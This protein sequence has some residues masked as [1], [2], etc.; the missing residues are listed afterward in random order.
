MNIIGGGGDIVTIF[1]F[2]NTQK[3]HA[4]LWNA[5]YSIWKTSWIQKVHP[6]AENLLQEI[7]SNLYKQGI[8]KCKNNDDD[9]Y[10]VY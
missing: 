9:D 1:I 4:D 5:K 10:C 8:S 2:G 7:L 6:A 3:S